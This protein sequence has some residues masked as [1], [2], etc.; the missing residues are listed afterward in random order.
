MQNSKTT[1]ALAQCPQRT[2]LRFLSGLFFTLFLWCVVCLPGKLFAAA[3]AG[4]TKGGDDFNT[5]SLVPATPISIG[6]GT[7]VTQCPWINTGMNAFVAANPTWAYTWSTT[8]LPGTLAFSS[9]IPWAANQ[10]NITLPDGTVNPGKFTNAERGGASFI[11][12]FNP[13]GGTAVNGIGFIQAYQETFTNYNSTT[14]SAINNPVSYV[15]LDNAAVASNP[16][17]NTGSGG[18]YIGAANQGAANQTWM[19]DR[20]NDPEPAAAD[21]AGTPAATAAAAENFIANVQFQVVVA[22]DTGAKVG[23]AQHNIVLYNGYWWGYQYSSTDTPEPAALAMFAAGAA[24]LVF[25]RRRTRGRRAP[26]LHGAGGEV[27]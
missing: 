19:E 15:K 26:G 14:G 23:G 25:I 7:S 20:P 11:T 16:F 4:P 3:T 2:K 8:A 21:A 13:Q 27:I 17:Y 24:A 22:V 9:Y 10:P 6:Q 12:T 18:G 1:I 5:T